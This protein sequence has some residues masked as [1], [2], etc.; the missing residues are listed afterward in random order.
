MKCPTCHTGLESKSHGAFKIQ[1][2]PS[3]HGMFILQEELKAIETAKDPALSLLDLELWKHRDQYEVL[4]TS[5]S[6]P[7]CGKPFHC[8]SYP[9]SKIKIN[10][11]HECHAVWLKEKE[12]KELHDYLENKLS[13]E[14][15]GAL[16]KDAGH[17][18]SQILQGKDSPKNINLVFK[19][20]EYR[21]FS[22]FP[23]IKNLIQSL[24][25]F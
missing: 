17:E 10:V 24:P 18:L 16:I 9:Q 2:C 15:M 23:F 21:I 20:L 25:K 6:C 3:C 1:T 22:Q 7:S 19:V 14:S 12:L 8:I 13:S 11:C 4:R 5:E